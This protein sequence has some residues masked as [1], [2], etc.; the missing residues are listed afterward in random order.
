MCDAF[1]D[2]RQVTRSVQLAHTFET[3]Q[4]RVNAMI[5]VIFCDNASLVHMVRCR[6]MAIE[7]GNTIG[8]RAPARER[9]HRPPASVER[10]TH[11]L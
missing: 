11:E 5:L 6:T 9:R 2:V 1:D 10:Q 7:G 8:S 4:T 3:T